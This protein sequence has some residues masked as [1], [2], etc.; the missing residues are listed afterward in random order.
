MA[1][2][3][4]LNAQ[5]HKF[6]KAAAYYGGV[7]CLITAATMFYYHSRGGMDQKEYMDALGDVNF[8]FLGHDNRS[9]F[10]FLS[11]Q[12]AVIILSMMRCGKLSVPAV[13]FTAVV[14]AAFF[15]VRSAASMICAAFIC[16]YLLLFRKGNPLFMNFKNYVIAFLTFDVLIVFLNIQ[17]LFTSFL[18]NVL[19]KS[20][21]ISG[22]T[23]I[24]AKA[25]SYIKKSFFIGYGRE[26]LAVLLVKFGINHVH[27]IILDIMY[28][29]GLI[30]FILYAVMIFMCGKS[31]MKYRSNRI[32]A[33]VSFIFFAFFICSIFDYYNT[34]AYPMLLYSFAV[35]IGRITAAAQ[36]NTEETAQK[37]IGENYVT[38]K[39]L[40]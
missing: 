4:G 33:T 20:T 25:M 1:A 2:E 38:N 6:I 28:S 31:L 7:M 17:N 39:K 10:I 15:Y 16:I 22:R 36:K 23:I 27:N 14:T 34:M 24:W 11:V 26:S 37:A 40:T 21:T 29:Q 30:G 9:Y 18:T 35:N 19:H 5:P 3:I 12:T 8:Y 13:L 32:S